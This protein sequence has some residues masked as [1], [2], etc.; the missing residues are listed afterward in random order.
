MLRRGRSFRAEPR[1]LGGV[2]FNS[3]VVMNF[4]QGGA[5]DAMDRAIQRRRIRRG[6]L[7]GAAEV[8]L[9]ERKAFL[10]AETRGRNPEGQCC[11]SD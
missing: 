8:V 3:L 11:K 4:G 7:G 2:R 5:E 6:G 1:G 10:H 9:C